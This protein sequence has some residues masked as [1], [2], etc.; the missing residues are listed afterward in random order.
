LSAFGLGMTALAGLVFCG[1]AYIYA[2]QRANAPE[3]KQLAIRGALCCSLVAWV[4]AIDLG[5]VSPRESLFAAGLLAFGLAVR[6]RA[7]HDLSWAVT[8][9]GGISFALWVWLFNLNAALTIGGCAWVAADIGA[10]RLLIR[11]MK[12]PTSK[13]SD[14]LVPSISAG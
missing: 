14:E 3:D 5:V 2:G 1:L 11:S 13:A 7:D 8:I 4:C 12:P 10:L 9:A 6:Y